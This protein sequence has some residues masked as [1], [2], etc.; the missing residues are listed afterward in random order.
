MGNISVNEP[1]GHYNQPL[2]FEQVWLMF[3]ETDKKIN[4]LTARF[5][6]QWG[7]LIESLVEG[8]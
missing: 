2:N 4:K 6:S 5:T 7:K 3:Q 1:S 8:N